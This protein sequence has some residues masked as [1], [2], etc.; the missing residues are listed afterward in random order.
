MFNIKNWVEFGGK[1]KIGEP[2][3]FPADAFARF[4]D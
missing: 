1:N 3:L 4:A 2:N